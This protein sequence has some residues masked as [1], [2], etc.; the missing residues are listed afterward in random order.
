ML[1][2][3]DC[4]VYNYNDNKVEL[5]RIQIDKLYVLLHIIF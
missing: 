4:F 5:N 2:W 3:Q 1:E